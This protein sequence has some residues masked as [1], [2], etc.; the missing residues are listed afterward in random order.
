MRAKSTGV[1][2]VAI[3]AIILPFGLD[4]FQL[5]TA[6]FVLIAAIGALGL[7]VLTG[8]T[9]QVSL[10]HA[11]FL[12]VGAYTA[13]VL[14]GDAHLS[15]AIWLPAAGV[16]AA[17]CGALIGPTALRLHGLYLA[18]VTI[19]LVYIGQHL[20]FN[21]PSISGGPGGRSVPPVTFGPFD[22]ASGQQ[23]TLG[24]LVIDHNGLYYYLALLILG[25]AMLFVWNLSRGRPGRA[26]QAVREREIAAAVMGV[27]LARTKMN[28]FVIS[29]FLA[30]VSG[31]LYASYLS[32]V[33][34]GQWSV[35]LSVQYVAAIIVGGIGTVWGPLLGSI[36]IFAL[37]SVLQSLIPQ[38]STGL[39]IDDIASIAFGVLIIAFFVLEPRGMV[40]LGRRAAALLPRAP[41]RPADTE[42]GPSQE[43][44]LVQR[45]DARWAR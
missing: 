19:G 45:R 3:A 33:T 4:A 23:L 26:M 1:V 16:V 42:K 12:A 8:Y 17:L 2:A 5:T 6:S 41:V 30:G 43:D 29:S 38:S 27:N 32:F 44:Q 20:W 18:I 25:A 15:A 31:A 21:V 11:F 39:P 28:A 40:G 7:N 9:G 24:G 14:G 37:P 35:L 10:G 13:A 34:P 22:F 36:V